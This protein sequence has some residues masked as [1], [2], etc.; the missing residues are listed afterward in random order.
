MSLPQLTIEKIWFPIFPAWLSTEFESQEV[1]YIAID[2]TKWECI[3]LLIVSL[4]WEQRAF[5][6]Y[7]ELLPKQGNSNFQQKPTAIRKLLPILK[8]HKIVVLG[9]R[10]FCDSLIGK[11]AVRAESVLLLTSQTK[12]VYFARR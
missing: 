10:E 8:P 2:R 11:L 3:N 4:I 9:D 12:R 1:L 6:I 7:W 5:P